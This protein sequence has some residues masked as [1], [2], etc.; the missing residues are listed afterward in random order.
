M[1]GLKAFLKFYLGAQVKTPKTKGL[2]WGRERRKRNANEREFRGKI[3]VIGD[4][5]CGFSLDYC[6]GSKITDLLPRKSLFN[7]GQQAGT[8]GS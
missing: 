1:S 7:P 8:F 2:Q 5:G 6:P 4:F 3:F